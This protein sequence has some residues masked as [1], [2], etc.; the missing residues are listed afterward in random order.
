MARRYGGQSRRLQ[1]CESAKWE[2]RY[3]GDAVLGQVVDQGVVIAM[4][5]IVLVLHANDL[6]G[7]PPFRDLRRR[8]VTQPDVTHEALAPV[9]VS[10]TCSRIGCARISTAAPLSRS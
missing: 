9:P 8:D 1:R 4:R 3:I 7:P 2:V 6:A 10:S 5:H